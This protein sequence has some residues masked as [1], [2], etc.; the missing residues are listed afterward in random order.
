[1]ILYTL[2]GNG[3][4]SYADSL[5]EDSVTKR[6]VYVN[7]TNRCNCA[8][9]FCL[10]TKK[11]FADGSS[12]WL[13]DEP[14]AEEIIA[15]F[16][17]HGLNAVKE[18]VFCG[19]GEPTLRLDVLLAVAAAIKEK[20]AS[21]KIRINTNG[22]AELEYQQEIAPLFAGLI[23]KI[24][25]SLN[26]ATAE[27]YL[28]ITRNRFGVGAYEA[29]L[30]FAQKCQPHVAQVALTVVDCIGAEKIAAC[31]SV[32]ERYGIDLRVRPME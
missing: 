28:A 3:Y 31:R 26:A 32:C 13:K 30:S 21:V 23:D 6:T 4:R 8:C 17:Q 11:T 16:E 9:T 29:M 27:E 20:D 19:F 2:Y 7:I 22:L 14:S 1:M 12:L 18:V 24:S 5:V 15:R 25:I 10:R